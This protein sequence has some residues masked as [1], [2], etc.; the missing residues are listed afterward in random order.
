MTENEKFI[1]FSDLTRAWGLAS[2]FHPG[3]GN[4]VVFIYEWGKTE[5]GL[6]FW[7]PPR[8]PSFPLH[9]MQH[10]N[11]P[12]ARG[13]KKEVGTSCNA[14]CRRQALK[15]T[16]REYKKPKSHGS[17]AWPPGSSSFY[18]VPVKTYRDAFLLKASKMSIL[19]REMDHEASVQHPVFTRPGKKTL[20][21]LQ[22]SGLVGVARLAM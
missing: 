3:P 6:T 19:L 5:L 13:L 16:P 21:W 14:R 2:S 8:G 12:L 18:H 10:S 15:H 1:D 20:S 9:V 11:Q 22:S 4:D 7:A 17:R